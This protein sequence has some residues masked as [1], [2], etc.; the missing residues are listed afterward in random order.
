MNSENILFD[1]IRKSSERVGALRSSYQGQYNSIQETWNRLLLGAK[2]SLS[3]K[4][5]DSKDAVARQLQSSGTSV[6]QALV[7]F[8][9]DLAGRITASFNEIDRRIDSYFDG[10][11]V[12][13]AASLFQLEIDNLDTDNTP[14]N[15][16]ISGS[17]R[18]GRLTPFIDGSFRSDQIPGNQVTSAAII[19]DD[20]PGYSIKAY[21]N[22]DPVPGDENLFYQK[23]SRHSTYGVCYV[24]GANG[25]LIKTYAFTDRGMLWNIYIETVKNPVGEGQKL[26]LNFDLDR[27]EYERVL[28]DAAAGITPG[29]VR[30][31][32]FQITR[33]DFSILVPKI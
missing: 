6:S 17:Y 18:R 4:T 15:G 7:D 20:L 31:F 22:I 13:I 11:S 10:A 23:Y 25:A 14:I 29:A 26:A 30:G 2:N 16:T 12:D 9:R 33:L 19:G 24:Y 5:Q 28:R 8:E 1:F 27:W 32:Y 21:L 3:G